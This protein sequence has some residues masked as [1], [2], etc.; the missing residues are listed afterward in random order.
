MPST[1]IVSIDEA[2]KRVAKESR[3]AAGERSYRVSRI[4]NEV[5]ALRRAQTNIDAQIGALE[6]HRQE[7]LR[8]QTADQ[9]VIREQGQRAIFEALLG[10]QVVLQERAKTASLLSEERQ[11]VILEEWKSSTLAGEYEEYRQFKEE[12]EPVLNTLPAS[13]RSVVIRH[14]QEVTGRLREQYSRQISRPVEV[15]GERLGFDIVMS[16]DVY[17]SNRAA[18]IIVLPV[19]GAWA[20]EWEHRDE[21]LECSLAYRVIQGVFTAVKGSAMQAG[22]LVVGQHLGLMVLEVDL[23]LSEVPDE[24][25]QRFT[26]AIEAAIESAGEL[27]GSH[28]TGKVTFVDV[29]TLLP[30]TPDSETDALTERISGREELYV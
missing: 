26:W 12:I 11:Q 20:S 15:P 30:D 2:M 16:L 25:G 9:G 19:G 1:P 21:D 23:V 7:L 10:Q 18:L 13:Y 29:D 8:Q 24:L 17:E 4:E 5:E 27:R 14:H 3:D 6:L 28:V 22:Q